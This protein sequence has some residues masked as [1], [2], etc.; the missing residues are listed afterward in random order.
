MD[1]PLIG[2]TNLRER[3]SLCRRAESHE[4]EAVAYRGAIPIEVHDGVTV[5]LPSRKYE[6]VIAPVA[7]EEIMRSFA[8]EHVVARIS[9]EGIVNIAAGAVDVSCPFHRHQRFRIGT[10]GEVDRGVDDV[11]AFTRVLHH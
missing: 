5:G 3:R 8:V 2:S 11:V 1:L 9:D 7:G 10:D 6:R 4:A